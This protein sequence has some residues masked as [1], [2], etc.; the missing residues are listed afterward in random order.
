TR[1]APSIASAPG[2]KKAPKAAP[3]SEPELQA[4]FA[5]F[6]PTQAVREGDG[7]AA[8][9]GDN[10]VAHLTLDAP[11]QEHVA[12]M[13]RARP[14]PRAAFVA[15]DPKTGKIL[16]YVSHNTGE[17]GKGDVVLDATP[18]S[19]SVFKLITASA[20][21]D[22]G[23]GPRRKKCFHG[24]A[25]GITMANLIDGPLDQRC[26]TLEEAVAG[27]IN[28]VFAKLSVG[29]LDSETLAR[30]A[31]AFGFGHALPFDVR[32]E[33][34]RLDVP[35]EDR[36]TLEFARTSAGFWHMHM[37]PLHGAVIAATLANGGRMAQP[38]LVERVTTKDGKVRYEAEPNVFREVIPR[39]TA[40]TV[41]R[42]MTG[43]VT[44]GTSRKAFHDA[45]GRPMV[46]DVSIAGKTGTLSHERPYRGYTWWVGFAPADKPTV[47]MA[48]LV[49][50]T[51]KWHIKANHVAADAMRF[52]FSR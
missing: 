36:E 42:M 21:V 38:Y 30:Y 35:D 19:A 13:F 26:N 27:S 22:R 1:A 17:F 50:N 10:L 39:S 29:H 48:V 3:R 45:R 2:A 33:V 46:P 9:L 5:D 24:G 23:V 6:D 49:V 47:A 31:S 25:S 4:P 34:S 20:L 16:A 32:T 51:P 28:A 40:R 8:A 12:G 37:S 44:S 15:M 41:G 7:F 14:T 18:P 52:Y 43:T 11:L